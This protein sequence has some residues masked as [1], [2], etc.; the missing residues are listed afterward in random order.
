MP[1]L[2]S[3]RPSLF[4]SRH[5]FSFS[6]LGLFVSSLHFRLSAFPSL[7][8]SSSFLFLLLILLAFS[9][10]ALATSSAPAF[11]PSHG[12]SLF[13]LNANGLYDVMKTNAIRDHI[14]SSR[15]HVWV[16][17]ETKS[18]PPVASRVSV[19]SYNIYETPAIRSS[20]HSSKWGVIAAVRNDLQ[21]QRVPVPHGLAGRVVAL[22]VIIPT[23]SAHGFS[24][25]I[26]AIYAPWD[27]GGPQPT[28]TQFWGMLTELCLDAPARSWCILGDCNLT[29]ASVETA[30][31]SS[32]SN[33]NRIPY[34]AFLRDTHGHDLWSTAMIA[35]RSPTLHLLLWCGAFHS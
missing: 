29:I 13:S 15:P 9:S 7:F 5:S 28:P 26:L 23:A 14:V 22:D 31:P 12:L 11:S 17:K 8:S 32:P 16:I 19:P 4:P 20:A 35:P 25:R 6:L 33:P 3:S 24:L 34:H 27:P 18:S 2:V 21:S 30:H 1:S 10:S